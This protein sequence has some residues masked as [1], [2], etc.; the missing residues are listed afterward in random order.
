MK[1]QKCGTSQI[2]GLVLWLKEFNCHLF[3]CDCEL[4]DWQVACILNTLLYSKLGI[5]SHHVVL[6]TGP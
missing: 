6:D 3:S 5:E 4:Q 2:G 1:L